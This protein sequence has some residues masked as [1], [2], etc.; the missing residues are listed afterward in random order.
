M[1]AGGVMLALLGVVSL[2]VPVSTDYGFVCEFT[3]SHMGYREW[4]FGFRTGDWY[5]AS[6][7]ENKLAG[8]IKHHWVSY[9][10]DVRNI[11]G[12]VQ[13]HRHG[14]PHHVALDADWYWPYFQTLTPE[15][16]QSLHVALQT[17]NWTHLEPLLDELERRMEQY[18]QTRRAKDGD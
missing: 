17:T 3:C 12:S 15:E 14:F 2:A 7:I 10:G 16:A 11:F 13:T 18:W 5:R 8:D 1:I 9:Q 6:P 4:I